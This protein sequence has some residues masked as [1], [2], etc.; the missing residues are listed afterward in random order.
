MTTSAPCPPVSPWIPA[1]GSVLLASTVWVAPSAVAAFSFFASMSTAMI[2][3]APA[4]AAPATAAT[5]TPPQPITAI[6][7][8]RVMAPVLIA[9]PIP[10]ITP[11]PRRPT[12]AGR[13]DASTLVH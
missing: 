8:P 13:A 2:G 7:L 9:A 12:A 5:P 10:A 11:H 1:T 3:D 4:R 6:D